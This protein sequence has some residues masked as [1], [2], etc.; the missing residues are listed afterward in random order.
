MP[1]VERLRQP[2]LPSDS[3]AMVEAANRIEHLEKINA[4]MLFVLRKAEE[5]ITKHRFAGTDQ[6]PFGIL[7]LIGDIIYRAK[8]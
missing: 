6:N 7:D 2:G 5:I 3:A 8:K 4:E 1:I